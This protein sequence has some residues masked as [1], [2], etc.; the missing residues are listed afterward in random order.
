MR[1]LIDFDLLGIREIKEG[2]VVVV[3]D[4]PCLRTEDED[5]RRDCDSADDV[6]FDDE[7]LEH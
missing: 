6:V 4:E 7:L 2:E 1:A 3:N 5:S